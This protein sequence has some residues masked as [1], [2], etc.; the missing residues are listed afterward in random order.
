MI[1]SGEGKRDKSRGARK[2][3]WEKPSDLVVLVHPPSFRVG[4]YNHFEL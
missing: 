3:W 2:G 1:W 4:D